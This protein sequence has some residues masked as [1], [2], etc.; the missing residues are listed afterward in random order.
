M[1]IRIIKSYR[2]VIAICDSELL[3]KK[4]EEGK[5]QLD[6][7]ESFYGKEEFSEDEAI[8][9]MKRMQKEDATFNI[10][11]KNSVDT[12]IKAGIIEKEGTKTIQGIPFALVLL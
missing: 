1:I 5:S 12:A 9:I 3:G 6:I 10:A 2:Y 4:F 7:K 11:G 8:A